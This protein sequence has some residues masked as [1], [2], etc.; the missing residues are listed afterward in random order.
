MDLSAY[1]DE[2][3]SLSR[4]QKASVNLEIQSAVQWIN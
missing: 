3:E 4:G 2:R 1:G